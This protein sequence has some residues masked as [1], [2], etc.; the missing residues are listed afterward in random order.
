MVLQH[1][2]P[3][4]RRWRRSTDA[5]LT[6][7]A[8]GSLPLLLLSLVTDRLSRVD[9][10]FLFVIDILVF[11][12]F[13]IDYLVEFTLASEKKTYVRSE[14]LSLVVVLAQ[15]AALAP[16]LSAFGILRAARGARI[17]TTIARIAGI[18]V[19]SARQQGL[20]TLKGQ[21]ARFAFGLAGMTWITSAVAFT[22]AED[23]GQG[24]RVH[25]FFDALWWSA[26]TITTVGYGDIYPVSAL[27]RVVAVFTMI[28]G[29]STLAVVTARVA[30]FLL[31]EP[32]AKDT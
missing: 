12:A 18:G 24:R 9:R 8:L 21:A 13:A 7:L 5:P 1:D 25:S 4:L 27:G 14:W 17:A 32:A 29:I 6:V 15:F 28:V 11:A 10:L 16:A 23:V 19:A 22:L 30:A 26:S 20:E 2:F 3:E 31:R